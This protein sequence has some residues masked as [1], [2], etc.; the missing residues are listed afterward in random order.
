MPHVTDYFSISSI[1][2]VS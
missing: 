2:F 1:R